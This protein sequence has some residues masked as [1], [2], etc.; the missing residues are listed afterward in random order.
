ME[1]NI[2][3]WVIVAGAIAV[4]IMIKKLYIKYQEAEE[5]DKILNKNTIPKP[6]PVVVPTPITPQKKTVVK[7]VTKKVAKKASKTK[8][9]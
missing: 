5:M 8:V 3:G 9:K 1:N 4:L 2:W 7:T 6:T